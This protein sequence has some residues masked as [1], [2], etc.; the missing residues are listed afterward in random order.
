[1]TN[2]ETNSLEAATRALQRFDPAPA[3]G[4]AQDVWERIQSPSWLARRPAGFAPMVAAF[5][6]ALIIVIAGRLIPWG[7][8]H[9]SKSPG[10]GRVFVEASSIVL[11]GGSRVL[12]G[13]VLTTHAPAE[14]NSARLSIHT[15]ANTRLRVLDGPAETPLVEIYTG[16][17]EIELAPGQMTTM[18]LPGTRLGLMGGRVQISVA[19]GQSKLTAGESPLRVDLQGRTENLAPG[20]SLLLAP[21][22]AAAKPT[23]ADAPPERAPASPTSEAVV[24]AAPKRDTTLPMEP[25]PS[26]P[27][28]VQ[29]APT[30]EAQLDLAHQ[31]AAV[32]AT[33][34]ETLAREVLG[35]APSPKLEARALA[36]LADARRR[37]GAK[38]EAAA[39]YRQV[40]E[41]SSGAPYA[42]EALYQAARLLYEMRRHK[43][44]LSALNEAHQRF[45]AGPLGPERHALAAA[46][47]EATGA[48]D[49]ARA[50]LTQAK[51]RAERAGDRASATRFQSQI[52]R[53]NEKR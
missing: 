38:D 49:E 26:A 10:R 47:Y 9:D 34:A 44:A 13:S 37:N 42:E 29:P 17:V 25:A 5:A 20:Q 15:A 36:I 52:D 4:A 53:L 8:E 33:R 51:A 7:A 50:E 18:L 32:D 28:P 40:A 45:D 2:H 12:P 11:E 21:K 46:V 1:M 31:V 3:K 23:A 14:I 16:E 30:A 6:M 27:D 41:H 19:D 24:P 39:L 35:R 48:M 22:K 43:E